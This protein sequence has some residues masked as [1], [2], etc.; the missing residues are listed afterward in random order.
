MPWCHRFIRNTQWCPGSSDISHTSLDLLALLQ[1]HR[2]VI[3]L[4]AVFLGASFKFQEVSVQ[5]KRKCTFGHGS[6]DAWHNFKTVHPRHQIYYTKTEHT[7]AIKTWTQ[8]AYSQLKDQ[9][10]KRRTKSIA[11]LLS[12]VW[13]IHYVCEPNKKDKCYKERKG[14]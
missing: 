14:S 10:L 8:Y 6:I 13:V 7:K 11:Q 9:R 12:S 4:R 1:P 2:V 5:D 3:S